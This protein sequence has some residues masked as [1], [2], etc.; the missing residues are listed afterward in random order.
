MNLRRH[1]AHTSP[2]HPVP[3]SASGRSIL[4]PLQASRPWLRQNCLVHVVHGFCGSIGEY[5]GTTVVF[6]TK[7]VHLQRYGLFGALACERGTRM[8]AR[9]KTVIGRVCDRPKH[10]WRYLFFI[11][12]ALVRR[13]RL[14][15]CAM[16]EVQLRR[17]EKG[18]CGAESSKCR[19]KNW[20]VPE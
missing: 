9:S 4:A 14:H 17:V 13:E 15:A 6:V 7:Q 16:T 19:S 8:R 10:A 11:L 1:F 5:K 18:A 12:F 2:S 20:K 3:V